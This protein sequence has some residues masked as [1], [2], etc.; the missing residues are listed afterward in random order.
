MCGHIFIKI[1]DIS[2]CIKCGITF[3]GQKVIF[4]RKL[5]NRKEG[6]K[7]NYDKKY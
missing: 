7:R 3:T 5:I 4:D 1:N 2:V 6:K